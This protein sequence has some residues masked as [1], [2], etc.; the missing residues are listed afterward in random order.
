MPV[1]LKDRVALVV[2]ASSG[3]GRACA[4]MLAAEG[5]KV[6]ASARRE[7]RLR[8]LKKEMAGHTL[9]I[10]A[11]DATKLAD[12]EQLVAETRRLLGEVNILVYATGTNTKERSTRRLTAEIW[13]KLISTNLNGAFYVT[14]A[15]LPAMREAKD[16][17]LIYISSISGHTPDVSGIA[18]QA[19]KRGMLG[20]AHGIRVEE[21]ENNIRTTVVCP[22]LVNSELLEN[23]P[24]KPSPEQLAQALT[25]EHVAEAVL[26]CAKLPP[27]AVITELTIVPTTL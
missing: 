25:P 20:M 23:R 11:A 21:R 7:D 10:H 19:S 4:A 16:G 2:G 5:A 22:G 8:Q 1:S 24:V 15:V 12:M 27:H 26:A 3:I 14:Q 13:D 17:H 6:M 9:E 18:Y